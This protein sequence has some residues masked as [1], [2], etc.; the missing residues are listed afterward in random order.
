MP[1]GVALGR[2]PSAWV[3]AAGGATIAP[4]DA[5]VLGARDPDE[6]NDIAELRAGALHALEILHPSE[7][8]ERGLEASGARAADGGRFWLHLD[9]DVLDEVVMPATD[10]LMRGGLDW[11]ELHALLGPL[12]ASPALAGASLGCLNPEKD[13]DG[14][15]TE[16][17]C[18]ALERALV[19]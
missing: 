15:F 18:V 8:R 1:L 4:E 10:Y 6:A 17:T 2:G 3:D 13:P 9:V 7:L 19:R 12:G 5:V 16:A 11:D 14:S